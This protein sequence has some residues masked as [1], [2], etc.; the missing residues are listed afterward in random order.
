MRW[1]FK[2]IRTSRISIRTSQPPR[3]KTLLSKLLTRA[4]KRKL[5]WEPK[6]R[7]RRRRKR[8]RERRWR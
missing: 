3:N 2:R 1:I 8:R 7:R 5:Y 4:R 6:G